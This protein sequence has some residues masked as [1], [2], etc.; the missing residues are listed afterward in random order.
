METAPPPLHRRPA[1]HLRSDGEY[2]GD[3]GAHSAQN[4]AFLLTD[5][6]PGAE[7]DWQVSN[8]DQKQSALFA[9]FKVRRMKR[10][11][12]CGKHAAS[13]PPP[14]PGEEPN[15]R[16]CGY[17]SAAS[18]SSGVD[19]VDDLI[20]RAQ[21]HLDKGWAHS[22]LIPLRAAHCMDPEHAVVTE[23]LARADLLV[24]LQREQQRKPTRP[25]EACGKHP[26]TRPCSKGDGPD[27][28]RW[29]GKCALRSELSIE[30]RPGKKKMC[31]K[32]AKRPATQRL[33]KS[34]VIN[35]CGQCIKALT[36]V[37]STEMLG[38]ERRRAKSESVKKK[39]KRSRK[40]REDA[41]TQARHTLVDEG[42]ARSRE[43]RHKRS[44]NG[45]GQQMKLPLQ[46]SQLVRMLQAEGMATTVHTDTFAWLLDLDI[47]L[48]LRIWL[49]S[50]R[51]ITP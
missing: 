7:T 6:R 22:A 2:A 23:M 14:A 51:G 12:L 18:R 47:V 34:K 37:A 39:K 43:R 19:T 45:P 27:K 50:C 11:E 13:R 29:C 3:G 15:F 41:S 35:Y 30:P 26:A 24:E 49:G 21:Q 36:A 42:T 20:A 32:C 5:L 16:W 4:A 9:T 31:S 38:S 40:N 17:C 33:Q 48:V 1:V 25:C 28:Y 44:R 8:V 46:Q 10:C